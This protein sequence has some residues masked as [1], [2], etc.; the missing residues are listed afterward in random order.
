MEG[1]CSEEHLD[2]G[3]SSQNTDCKFTHSVAQMAALDWL[4]RPIFELGG[5]SN[6]GEDCGF[7]QSTSSS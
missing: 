2:P 3:L 6:I 5:G 7:E 4:K 1:R